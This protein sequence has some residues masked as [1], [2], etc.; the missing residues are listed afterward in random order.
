MNV[1]WVVLGTCVV[2]VV[3][4][5]LQAHYIVYLFKTFMLFAEV[6]RVNVMLTQ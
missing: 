3:Y 6:N 5:A 4:V 2:V 1:L